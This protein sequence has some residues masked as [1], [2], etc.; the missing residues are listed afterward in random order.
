VGIVGED[1]RPYHQGGD[2]DCRNRRSD[3]RQHPTTT[4]LLGAAFQLPFEFALGCRTS[5]FV[6]RHRRYPSVVVC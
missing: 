6:G 3:D 1:D 2:N 4:C 5:L